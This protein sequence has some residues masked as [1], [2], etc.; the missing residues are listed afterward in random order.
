M[1]Q[2]ESNNSSGQETLE[3]QVFSIYESVA[4]EVDKIANG[5]NDNAREQFRL[6]VRELLQSGVDRVENGLK[7]GHPSMIH[8]QWVISERNAIVNEERVGLIGE[9]A[10]AELGKLIVG[11]CVSVSSEDTI[12]PIRG[13]V[14]KTNALLGV[15]TI[16]SDQE[17]APTEVF[18]FDEED[19][20]ERS[21]R[22]NLQFT[23]QSDK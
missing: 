12:S 22:V 14:E 4:Q 7:N 20:G 2:N 16:R 5:H 23:D 13:R 10:D 9:R 19:N 8:R 21:S 1:L 11:K 15:L 6:V 17:D 18:L 3:N